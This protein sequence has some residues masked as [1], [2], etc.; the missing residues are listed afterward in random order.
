MQ[1]I[2]KITEVVDPD[3]AKSIGAP[4][5]KANFKE[6][7]EKLMNKLLYGDPSPKAEET[8]KL[9]KATWED[10]V[11][12]LKAAPQAI[13]AAVKKLTDD[14]K[15]CEEFIKNKAEEAKKTEVHVSSYFT[16][17]DGSMFAEQQIEGGES[18]PPAEESTQQAKTATGQESEISNPTPGDG[19]ASKTDWP[20]VVTS[21]TSQVVPAVHNNLINALQG[22]FYNTQYKLYRDIVT[23]YNS[24][25]EE[26]PKPATA[27]V[28]KT[29]E[30]TG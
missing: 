4:D 24:Q 19:E 14:M 25:Y 10:M 17:M 27:T 9:D 28:D 6:F 22:K 30:T 23:A 15:Q 7:S 5:D 18:A 3:I 8:K 16:T 13:E 1:I 12:N 21:Y 20:N 2:Q 29:G 11:G 26:K